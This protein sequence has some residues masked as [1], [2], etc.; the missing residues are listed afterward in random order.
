MNHLL[1]E[2]LPAV[3]H[4]TSHA[5]RN[6]WL[7]FARV[8]VGSACSMLSTSESSLTSVEVH[9]RCNLQW[10]QPAPSRITTKNH[11]RFPQRF[12]STVRFADAESTGWAWAD[13]V[14]SQFCGEH[15]LVILSSLDLLDQHRWIKKKETR[16][17]CQKSGFE[18]GLSEKW[19]TSG[20]III[21]HQPGKTWNKKI[22]LPKWM[23]KIMVPKP[24]KMDDLV[25]FPYFWFNTQTWVPFPL[26]HA[27][28][29]GAKR[30][31]FGRMDFEKYSRLR[32]INLNQYAYF[33][34]IH[35]VTV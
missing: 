7:C 27:T 15:L 10:L 35:T 23:V 3:T 20:Q 8:T 33:F 22:S 28:L 9:P 4:R 13:E 30:W 17:T 19:M 18:R 34:T 31:F 6:R 16:K 12:M 14:S 1:I 5:F 21:I 32:T 25:V 11:G 29:L 2:S 26:Q 24:I